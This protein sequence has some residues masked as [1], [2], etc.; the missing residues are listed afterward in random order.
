MAKISAIVDRKSRVIEGKEE[1]PRK[2]DKICFENVHF[3][4]E[5]PLLKNFNLKI[6]K[7]ITAFIGSSGSGKTTIINLIMRFYD[8]FDGKIYFESSGN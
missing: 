7:G 3:Q 6:K 2:I 5:N 4:Y 8:I 1:V